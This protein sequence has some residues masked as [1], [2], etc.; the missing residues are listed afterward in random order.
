MKAAS[1][2]LAKASRRLF[3][4]DEAGQ[5][6]FVQALTLPQPFP[7]CILWSRPR[8]EPLPF[9][10][11]PPLPWQPGFVD[12]VAPSARPGQHDLHDHGAYY[13]LDGS[14]VFAASVL[15]QI[16]PGVPW[17]IDLCA[18]PGGKSLFA[19]RSLQPGCLIS[20]EVIGKRLG[21][22]VANLRR[23]QV[24]P[25]VV[26]RLDSQVFAQALPATASVVIVDAPCSGQSLLAKGTK[27][28]GCFHPVTVN[29]NANR[30]KR[31]VANAAQLV[32][33]QGYLAYMTCTYSVE[34]NEQVSEWLLERFP[35]LQP[36]AIPHL[37]A[38]QSHLSS[39]SCYRLWPQTGL[40]AGAFTI[41]LQNTQEDVPRAIPSDFFQQPGIVQR[42]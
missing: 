16:S 3:P 2:L 9:A 11:E 6:A 42:L 15:L 1:N 14:S 19:W 31:I 7:S 23:C 25:A 30:Q 26:T 37:A 22:L 4:Q 39:L 32:A 29:K 5:T 13:C 10:V 35:H 17:V 12:R 24:R 8:P 41:L 18:A 21:P 34:E 40:G 38:H 20:N 33:P 36:V 27:A 28:P